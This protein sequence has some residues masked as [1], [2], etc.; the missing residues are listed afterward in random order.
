[1]EF[2]EVLERRRTVRDF[3][4]DVEVSEEAL[5]RIIGAAFK[6][7]TNDHLRQLEFAVMRDPEDIARVLAPLEGNIE[8]FTKENVSA[9]KGQMDAD[10]YAMFL[11]AMPKQRRMLAQSRCLVLPFFRQQGAPLLRPSSQS[12]LNY[13]ASAWCAVENML[14]AAAAEG[15]ACAFHIPIEAEAEHVKR[16]AG[17]PEGYEL[18]C[19]LA[20]GHPAP[21]IRLPKQKEIDPAD[22]IHRG[23][24]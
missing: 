17:A 22:R 4:T 8:K 9:L 14:L 13:F 15:L 23:G 2:Y 24:W 12:S 20:V 19:L 3:R 6:A 7:P 11:D 5:A 21:G 18:A 16:T 1:M 10:E